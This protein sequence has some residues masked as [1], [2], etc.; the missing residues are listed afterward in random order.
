VD[1]HRQRKLVVID[2]EVAFVG[3]IDVTTS[4]LIVTTR[5][6]IQRAG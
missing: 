5:P 4:A 3:G 6:S 1:A 2:D